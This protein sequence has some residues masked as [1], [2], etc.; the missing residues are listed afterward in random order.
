MGSSATANKLEDIVT[1]PHYDFRTPESPKI[2]EIYS[3]EATAALEA[4]NYEW[5][6]EKSVVVP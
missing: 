6:A 4:S 2:L 1:Y 3:F 5:L